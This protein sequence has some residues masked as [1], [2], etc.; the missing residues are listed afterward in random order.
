MEGGRPGSGDGTLLCPAQLPGAL[1]PVAANDLIGIN[2]TGSDGVVADIPQLCA[3]PCQLAP[4]F[5]RCQSASR[6][7]LGPAMAAM[8]ASDGRRADRS[9]LDA[10]DNHNRIP[11]SSE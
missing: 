6:Q 10:A 7:G 9:R 4:A 5:A 2:S 8:H 11:L 1:D 3:A